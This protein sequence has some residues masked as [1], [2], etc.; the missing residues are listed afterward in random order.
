MIC[1]VLPRWKRDYR[2]WL[3][4]TSKGGSYTK[5]RNEWFDNYDNP[6]GN[7][8]TGSRLISFPSTT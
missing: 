3:A 5:N 1:N 8:L 2:E 7:Q 6:K 4:N